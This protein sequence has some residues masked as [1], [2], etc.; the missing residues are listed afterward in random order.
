MTTTAS[1]KKSEY[2]GIAIA[3]A[4]CGTWFVLGSL[5]PI[6]HSTAHVDVCPFDAAGDVIPDRAADGTVIKT[7]GMYFAR[8]AGSPDSL[9]AKCLDKDACNGPFSKMEGHIGEPVH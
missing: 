3:L 8:R 6:W 1:K 2:R 9:L 7:A 4:I 5:L